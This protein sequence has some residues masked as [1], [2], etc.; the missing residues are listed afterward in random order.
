MKSEIRV[1]VQ[2]D[3]SCREPEVII[4]T[5]ERTARVDEIAAAVANLVR[6]DEKN[7]SVYRGGTRTLLRQREI[8]RV[9]TENKRLVVCS[10]QGEFESRSTLQGV[11]AQLNPDLFLR[12]SRFEIVN[13]GK[14]LNFDFSV[15]GTIKVTF[16]DGS[17]TWVARRYVRAIEERL[18][19]V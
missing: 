5:R 14:I 16:E 1:R 6:N 19:P 4:R 18:A 7:L 13:L 15:S 12:I 9:Y 8:I 17:S 3:P 11:E 10:A 2:V